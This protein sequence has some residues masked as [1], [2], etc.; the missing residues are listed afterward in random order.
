MNAHRIEVLYRADNDDIIIEVTHYLEFIFLPPDDRFL[1]QDLRH[2]R[3]SKAAFR[4]VF[5]LIGIE[6]C[7]AS[8]TAESVAGTDDRGV[9]DILYYRL[10]LCPVV[11]KP[12]P[13]TF[14][15]YLVHCCF[16]QL[17]IFSNFNSINVGTNEF[18]PQAIKHTLLIQFNR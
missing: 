15:P 16:E 17:T 4:Y 12:A 18:N 9:S 8:G 10:C 1:D 7:T 2:R 6:C 11:S 5:E 13:W 14:D 3:G